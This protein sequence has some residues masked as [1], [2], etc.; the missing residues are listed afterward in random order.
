MVLA[1]REL[2]VTNIEHL[3]GFCFKNRFTG[4]LS[5]QVRVN[6]EN[7][8][9]NSE[10]GFEKSIGQ[11]IP[12]ITRYDL[13][14]HESESE[15]E[16]KSKSYINAHA[17]DNGEKWHFV[18]VVEELTSVKEKHSELNTQYKV[19][20]KFVFIP[21]SP[22]IKGIGVDYLK[23]IYSS[24]SSSPGKQKGNRIGEEDLSGILT[25][26]NRLC[27][28]NL[29]IARQLG[30]LEALTLRQQFTRREFE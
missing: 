7:Q 16:S 17:V 3:S 22:K 27:A 1:S 11:W 5:I 28:L 6:D 9:G 8:L 10:N 20:F 21:F 4:Y 15:S 13:M 24:S 18:G 19:K 26:A 23:P 25:P 29:E 30:A 2:S 12:V 14:R